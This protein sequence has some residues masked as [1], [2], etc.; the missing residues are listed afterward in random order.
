MSDFKWYFPKSI[1]EAN[2]FL[3]IDGIIPHAG[4]TFLIRTGMKNIDGLVDLKNLHLDY[5]KDNGDLL[6]IGAM[7]T[8]SDVAEF[9]NGKNSEHILSKSLGNAATTPL[10]NRITIGGSIFSFPNWSD[11]VGPL[12]AL[13]ATVKIQT[14][15]EATEIPVENYIGNQKDFRNKLIMGIMIPLREWNSHYYRATR[16]KTDHCAFNLTI[17]WR[18]DGDILN[19]IR[20]VVVGNQKRYAR[21]TDLENAL[22]G[23]EI[24]K[25]SPENIAKN[26]DVQFA[27]KK[28]GSGEYLKEIFAVELERGIEEIIKTSS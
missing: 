2:E 16:T 26:T 5:I 3:K 20:I 23:M 19:D 10:R 15:S 21:L 25:I 1:A 12:L 8:F 17:L 4:G 28:L 13:D 6:E 22:R 14:D 24:E 9:F 27:D 7:A 11:L 18:T